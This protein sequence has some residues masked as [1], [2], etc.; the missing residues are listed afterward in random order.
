MEL[1]GTNFPRCLGKVRSHHD[2]LLRME[3]EL[4][5]DGAKLPSCNIEFVE[6]EE[7]NLSARDK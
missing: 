4:E 3:G 6:S 5:E 7:D 2:L 1:R